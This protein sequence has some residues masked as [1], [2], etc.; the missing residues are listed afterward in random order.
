MSSEGKDANKGVGAA[1]QPSAV[2]DGLALP[3]AD[4]ISQ[5]VS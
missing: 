3:L 1:A 5:V 4:A 2:A